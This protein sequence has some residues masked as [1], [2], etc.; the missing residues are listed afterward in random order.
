MIHPKK[1]AAVGPQKIL[2]VDD[3]PITRQGIAAMIGLEP[4]LHVCGEAEDAI[5]A[6]AAVGRLKPDLV[7]VDLS[8]PGRNGLEFLKD[9]GAQ[10]PGIAA[11]V[12][13]MHDESLYAERAIRAGARG[14]LMKSAG[15]LAVMEAIRTVLAGRIFVSPAV[16][17]RILE[18]IARPAP[19]ESS[20]PGGPD[21][22]MRQLSD[23]EFEVFQLIGQGLGT[24]EIAG[25]LNLGVKTVEAHRAHL[26]KKLQIRDATALVREAVRWTEAQSGI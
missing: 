17:S 26:E 7:V 24:R 8:L 5:S 22:R 23:R 13:S 15:G 10:H 12:L 20:Q 6:I 16:S 9:L 3:H 25:R 14:Y 1:R 2:L 4:D 11:L 21:A 19:T 18:S